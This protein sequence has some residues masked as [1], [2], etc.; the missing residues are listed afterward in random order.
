[1]FAKV[2]GDS[3]GGLLRRNAA[4][5]DA[6]DLGVDEK[7]RAIRLEC[8]VEQRLEG[9]RPL[10]A[11]ERIGIIPR[12]EPDDERAAARRRQQIDRFRRRAPKCFRIER[13]EAEIGAGSFDRRHYGRGAVRLKAAIFLEQ[14][15]GAKHEVAGVP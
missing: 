15:G 8:R 3:L 5:Q 9:G 1:M 7:F 12:R 4:G 11:D 6:I 13:D 2:G 10:R 14:E